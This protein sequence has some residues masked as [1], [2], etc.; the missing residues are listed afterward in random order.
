MAKGKESTR[1]DGL[2]AVLGER[3]RDAVNYYS[4]ELVRKGGRGTPK[5]VNPSLGCSH[6]RSSL[7]H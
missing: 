4:K 5:F 1:L 6:C 3:F 7:M 2:G